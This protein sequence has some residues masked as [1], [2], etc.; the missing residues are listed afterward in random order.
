MTEMAAGRIGKMVFRTLLKAVG[1]LGGPVGEFVTASI[2]G[3]LAASMT[4]G[5]GM[6]AKHYFKNGMHETMDELQKVFLDAT[7][8]YRNASE[9]G[10]E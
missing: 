7:E 5:I 9:G 8:F 4:Y 1:W 10:K 3:V 2:A 6:A